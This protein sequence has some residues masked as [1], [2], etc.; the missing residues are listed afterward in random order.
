MANGDWSNT[1]KVR[2]QSISFV[3]DDSL[4]PDIVSIVI[5]YGVMQ[6]SGNQINKSFVWT[7]ANPVPI[8]QGI[9]AITTALT[10]L[11][12]YEGLGIG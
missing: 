10:A 4:P 12:Q 3:F 1:C 7:P 9:T 5:Q 8:N 11:E 6:P 2:P